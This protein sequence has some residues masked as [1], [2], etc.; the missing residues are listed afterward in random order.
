MLNWQDDNLSDE[1]EK[2]IKEQ[3][4][5]FLIACPGSGK[6]RTLTCKIAYEL[7][8]IKSSKD[9]IAG[10]T[11]TNRAANEI[12]ERISDMRIETNQLWLGTIHSFC[13]EWIIK[14]YSIYSNFL[15]YGYRV[16]N[17]YDS[18]KL[19]TELCKPYKNEGITHWDCK[20]LF[21]PSG[22]KLNCKDTRKHQSLHKIFSE[23]FDTLSKNKQI[24]FELILYYS[25]L[26]VKS[27]KSIS[28]LLSKLFRYILVD[29]Y[30][31]TKEIQYSILAEIIKAGCGRTRS[32]IVGDPNQAIYTSLGGYPISIE[33]FSNMCETEFLHLSLSRNY[34]SSEKLIKYFNHYNVNKISI[35]SASKQRKYHSK[36]TFNNSVHRN[37]VSEEIVNLIQINIKRYK[38]RPESI[39]ILAPQWA[40]LASMTRRLMSLL[41]EYDFDGPG[42][43]PFAKDI[44]NFWYKLSKIALTT[45]SPR[46]YPRRLRWATEVVNELS[47]AGV[48]LKGLTNKRLLRITNSIK[49]NESNG[50]NYLAIF[51]DSLFN[52]I[53]VDFREIPLLREH[54]D[55]FFESSQVRIN[56]LVKQGSKALSD[57]SSFRKVFKQKTGITIS[58]IHGVKGAEFD[59]VI[60][61]CLLDGIVPHFSDP[62]PENSASK[63]L[64][65][66]ASRARKNLHLISEKGRRDNY[67]REDRLPTPILAMNDFEYDF[68]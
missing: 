31:D 49:I 51:F 67:T 17:S 12:H 62:D 45:A 53:N 34:R 30:Q 13:I 27:N 52:A 36:I 64:Y 21:T 50:L 18:E 10:I 33:E 44:E 59:T 55:C 32:F 19:L 4:N 25:Y 47:N 46:M 57:I 28:L 66:L 35:L 6:T 24:D 56:I 26:L 60:A 68:I 63:M 11:F 8:R 23:Y 61:Y 41:P 39:C 48:D 16:I 65:V 54:Y 7:S 20:Y 37:N 29:E 22:Y 3:K 40:N 1:Q 9:Y 43:V 15:K 38:I 42:M 5:I 2:A 14:P 58:T